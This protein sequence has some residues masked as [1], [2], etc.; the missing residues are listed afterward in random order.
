MISSVL[1][2]LGAATLWGCLLLGSLPA[3]AQE[4]SRAYFSAMTGPIERVEACLEDLGMDPLPKVLQRETLESKFPFIGPGGLRGSGSIGLR[5][6]PSEPGSSR[7]SSILLFPISKKIA[8]LQ[9][10]TS[11]GARPLPGSDDTVRLKGNLIRRSKGFL[12]LGNDEQD[13]TQVDP[14]ALEDRLTAEG[15][16][17]E[18]DIDLERWRKSDP[19]TFYSMFTDKDPPPRTFSHLYKLGYSQ[20]TRVFQQ[21]LTRMRLALAD[22]GPALRL[23]MELAPVAPAEI[24]PLPRPGFPRGTLGRVDIAYSSTESSQWI[25]RLAEQFMDAAEKDDLFSDAERA[26]VESSELRTLFEEAFSI[27]WVA[28]AVSIALEPVDG[29]IVY[30]QVN[31]YRSPAG[32]SARMAAVVKKLNGLDAQ[33]GR[34]AKGLGLTTYEA[35]GV[36]VTRLTVPGKK[37]TI[38]F[39]EA[40]TTVRMV[41][42]NDT[43]RRVPGLLKLPASG[44]LTSSFSGEFDPI[45]S[46]DAYI[47]SGG[48]L[49]LPLG[50]KPESLRGQLITWTTHAAGEAAVVDLNVPKPLARSFIQLLGNRSYE[51]N[52]SG[53]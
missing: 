17:A 14:L 44:T 26:G 20:S 11:R 2:S 40:G 30:H 39:A 46:V 45:T 35:S 4:S 34:N 24:A 23:R 41:I 22:T 32:F 13:I 31:Q 5:M 43:V 19:N 50:Y 15:T 38:D 9:E 42:A 25:Q 29:H 36:R 16:L 6:G 49:P 3:L 47:A 18:L 21:V 7:P 12:L 27:L 51:M 8:P 33:Q 10:F 53:F 52:T 28:D 37:L 48:R 1:R